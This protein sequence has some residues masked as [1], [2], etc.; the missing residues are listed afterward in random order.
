MMLKF[1]R[2]AV[3]SAAVLALAAATIS[4]RAEADGYYRGGYGP[5]GNGYGSGG[6]YGAAGAAAVAKPMSRLLRRLAAGSMLR[7]PAVSTVAAGTVAA[8]MAPVMA[9]ATVAVTTVTTVISLR[10]KKLAARF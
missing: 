2:I 3:V 5:V 10:I 4:S 9:A 7:R 6:Y 8:I 1:G